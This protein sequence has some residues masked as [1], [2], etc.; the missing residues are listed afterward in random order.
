M[1]PVFRTLSIEKTLTTHHGCFPEFRG[2]HPFCFST[3]F[4]VVIIVDICITSF[5]KRRKVLEYL[6]LKSVK[7]GLNTTVI[8]TITFFRT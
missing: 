1:Y 2:K 3:D 4:S 5:C 7:E 8:K 6:F